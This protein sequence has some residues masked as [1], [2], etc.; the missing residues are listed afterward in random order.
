MVDEDERTS[1][2][3]LWSPVTFTGPDTSVPEMPLLPNAPPNAPPSGLPSAP[4]PIP[5]ATPPAKPQ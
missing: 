3:G 4:A 2:D 1:N 5:G